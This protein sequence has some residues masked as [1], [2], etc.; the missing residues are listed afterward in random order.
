[1][2]E[3]NSQISLME[4]TTAPNTKT[5]TYKIFQGDGSTWYTNTFTLGGINVDTWKATK[6]LYVTTNNPEENYVSRVKK[7]TT[8]KFNGNTILSSTDTLERI[9]PSDENSTIVLFVHV[10][11]GT[12]LKVEY[13]FYD[14]G[15]G[16]TWT[17]P[18]NI[19]S[20]GYYNLVLQTKD[21]L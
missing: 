20:D 11:S 19:Y 10:A 6:C 8:Q 13:A 17:R 2:L 18:N 3:T 21:F 16:V 12:S 15:E 5:I 4:E 9:T 1:M 14:S 7:L